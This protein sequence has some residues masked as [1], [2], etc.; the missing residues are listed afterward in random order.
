MTVYGQHIPTPEKAITFI[1][2]AFSWQGF[3]G[4]RASLG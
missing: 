4:A 3:M 2:D 1:I